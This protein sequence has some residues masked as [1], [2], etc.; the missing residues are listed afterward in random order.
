MSIAV[1]ARSASTAASRAMRRGLVREP[2]R[3]RRTRSMARLRAVVVIHA[4]GLSGMPSA[5]QRS[6]ATR[7]ASGDRLLG[8]V[9]VA[10]DPDEGRE[11][12]AVSSRNRRSTTASRAAA[13]GVAS[14]RRHI[15]PVVA[16][17]GR[18]STVPYSAAGIRAATSIASSRSRGLDQVV[19]AEVLLGLGERPV[20][21]DPP[22]VAEPDRRG[23]RDGLERLAAQELA[24]LAEPGGVRAVPRQLFALRVVGGARPAARL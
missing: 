19:P 21:D 1:A 9:E 10:Q 6:S 13:V 16:Q 18:T 15:D 11:G 24:A 22:A 7:Y 8:E 2:S 3:A 17:I 23:V 20:G 12:P 14:D 4:P 5:G